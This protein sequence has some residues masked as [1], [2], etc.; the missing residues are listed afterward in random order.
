M[1]EGNVG[2]DFGEYNIA[3]PKNVAKLE[4]KV[5]KKIET[6]TAGV[7]E[8]TQKE[9][10]A[11]VLGLGSFLH[12]EHYDSWKTIKNDWESGSQYFSKSNIH[13]NAKVIVRSIGTIVETQK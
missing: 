1:V 7:V 9:Y 3:E 8:K 13:V 11:D 5:A 10:N 4:E 12:Q 6:L 2:E